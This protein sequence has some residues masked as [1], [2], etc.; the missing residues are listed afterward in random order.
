MAE[1][2]RESLT[3]LFLI[4]CE[5]DMLG[6][7]KRLSSS[8]KTREKHKSVF[9]II[10]EKMR[11]TLLFKTLFVLD[12]YQS[13]HIWQK[14]NTTQQERTK[15]ARLI[16]Q[17]KIYHLLTNMSEG[18]AFLLHGLTHKKRK[19]TK[20]NNKNKRIQDAMERTLRDFG[21]VAVELIKCKCGGIVRNE[22]W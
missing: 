10:K 16:L 11:R 6:I 12:H 7:G 1:Y 19:Q 13:D 8:K 14:Q 9:R 2:W 3:K 5:Q 21:V 20:L 4:A 17:S 22:I 18:K 15:K